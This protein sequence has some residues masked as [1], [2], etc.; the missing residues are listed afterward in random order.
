MIRQILHQLDARKRESHAP[1]RQLC[2]VNPILYMV[3][4]LRHGILGRSDVNPWVGL[5][6]LGA[7]LVAGGAI[8]YQLLRSGYKLRT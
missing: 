4:G 7:M 8:T 6:I 3:E 2:Y 5:G 1:W